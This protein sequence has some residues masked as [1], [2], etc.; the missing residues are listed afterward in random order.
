[1]ML[2]VIALFC[3]VAG[4]DRV[5]RAFGDFMV[6]LEDIQNALEDI[7]GAVDEKNDQLFNDAND[8]SKS[9]SSVTFVMA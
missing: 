1:M 5:L 6:K 7:K 3:L 9:C 2:I 8:K 4:L